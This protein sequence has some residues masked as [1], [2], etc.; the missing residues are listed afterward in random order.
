MKNFSEENI[1]NLKTNQDRVINQIR[2]LTGFTEDITQKIYESQKANGV[3]DEEIINNFAVISKP[4]TTIDL[5]TFFGSFVNGLSGI[6]TKLTDVQKTGLTKGLIQAI[7]DYS[8][9]GS[10]DSVTL[11]SIVNELIKI[12]DPKSDFSKENSFLVISP[13]E[14]DFAA[15]T[16]SINFNIPADNNSNTIQLFESLKTILSKNNKRWGNAYHIQNTYNAMMAYFDKEI[17]ERQIAES[18]VSLDNNS[19][20]DL[21]NDFLSGNVSPISKNINGV[22][23]LVPDLQTLVFDMMIIIDKFFD[24]KEFAL[25]LISRQTL[26]NYSDASSNLLAQISSSRFTSKLIHKEVIDIESENKFKKDEDGRLIEFYNRESNFRKTMLNGIDQ[27]KLKYDLYCIGNKSII[28]IINFIKSCSGEFNL[29]IRP[30]LRTYVTKAY[31]LLSRVDKAMIES[32]KI[33]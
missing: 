29:K 19:H 13:V 10:F 16:E 27:N 26:Q 23:H 2:S 21:L 6:E 31:E 8:N 20:I 14:S 12:K 11:L 4:K 3:S 32:N 28:D 30:Y 15:L 18:M 9:D 1:Q 22:K 25:S 7:N 24:S 17:E 5:K 33:R